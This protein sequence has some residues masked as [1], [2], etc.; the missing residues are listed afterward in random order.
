MQVLESLYQDEAKRLA[1]LNGVLKL[2]LNNTKYQ[3]STANEA[4]K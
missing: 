4:I 3:L 2:E 1:D